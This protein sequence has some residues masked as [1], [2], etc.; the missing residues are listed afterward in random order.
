MLPQRSHKCSHICSHNSIESDG[1]HVTK[2]RGVFYYRRRLPSPPGGEVAVSLGT[3]N[4]R[5]AEHLA[6]ML[7]EAFNELMQPMTELV[8]ENRTVV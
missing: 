5:E 8:P 1:S 7:D 6:T 4:Y 2:K 3:T